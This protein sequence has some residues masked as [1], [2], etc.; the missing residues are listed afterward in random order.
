MRNLFM[1]IDKWTKIM[2][3]LFMRIWVNNFR[4]NNFRTHFFSHKFHPSTLNHYLK[5]I[6]PLLYHYNTLVIE[7]YKKFENPYIW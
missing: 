3:N 6:F 2:R 5:V 1:R 4:I 7:K